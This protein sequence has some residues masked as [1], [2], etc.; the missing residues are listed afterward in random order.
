MSTT[1]SQRD[2]IY[3]YIKRRPTNGATRKEVE[4]KLGMLHQ[5]VGPRVRELIDARLIREVRQWRDDSRV[6]L[7][8]KR[9]S[10]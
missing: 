8:I 2:R 3:A 5:S 10:R 6:L 1:K 4:S 9:G 7:A